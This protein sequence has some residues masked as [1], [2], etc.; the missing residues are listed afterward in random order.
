M[1]NKLIA[2]LTVCTILLAFVL[3]GC[4]NDINDSPVTLIITVE[5]PLSADKITFTA[6]QGDVSVSEKVF[7]VKLQNRRRVVISVSAD[8][9]V[10]QNLELTSKDFNGN[11]CLK[12]VKL[13]N[14]TKNTFLAYVKCDN[15]VSVSENNQIKCYITKTNNNFRILMPQTV[16]KLSFTFRS[17]GFEPF[18]I[19]LRLSDFKNGIYSTNIK[20]VPVGKKLFSV[21]SQNINTEYLTSNY[22]VLSPIQTINYDR[23]V[24]NYII[25]ANDTVVLSTRAG[26]KIILDGNLI[27][28]YG[29]EIDLIEN[30]VPN[31]EDAENLY[32][33]DGY[34]QYSFIK[35]GN[36]YQPL[37]SHNYHDITGKQLNFFKM[38][39]GS[40]FFIVWKV[41]YFNSEPPYGLISKTVIFEYEF[42]D[43]EIKESKNKPLSS[44]D[45]IVF[46]RSIGVLDGY[47][48]TY[49]G[50]N[51]IEEDYL[52]KAGQNGE[53]ILINKDDCINYRI[54]HDE[55]TFDGNKLIYKIFYTEYFNLS[56]DFNGD[57]NLN[58]FMFYI[59]GDYIY[60]FNVNGNTAILKKAFFDKNG[61]IHILAGDK[62]LESNNFV[63][64]DYYILKEHCTESS[65]GYKYTSKLTY[66]NYEQIKDLYS[67][68]NN[69][70]FSRFNFQQFQKVLISVAVGDSDALFN[71]NGEHYVKFDTMLNVI[72]VDYEY[73]NEFNKEIYYTTKQPLTVLQVIDL[74]N[75]VGQ[76][77]PFPYDLVN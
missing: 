8:G 19:D 51:E 4:A 6:S 3:T 7:T 62:I 46:D 10:T 28:T 14:E 72:F 42:S 5:T 37:Q 12:T 2:F 21:K 15:T 32:F 70:D 41:N 16:E 44:S 66:H 24:A 53:H 35:I 26:D 23:D 76:H 58:K 59:N 30:S 25:D 50:Q 64:E 61:M 31:A 45:I 33:L 56:L 27:P 52:Y 38:P 29:Y 73:D 65:S 68:Y 55:M 74:V 20:L 67:I 75:G 40:K 36:E 34:F 39:F 18:S 11:E 63:E 69:Y 54:L 60:D 1:K 13:N 48:K 77:E 22:K 49:H 17:D 47:K 71:F 57:L 9:Y 43:E